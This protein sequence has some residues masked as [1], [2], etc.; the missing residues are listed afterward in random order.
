MNDEEA[1][2]EANRILQ[3]MLPGLAAKSSPCIAVLESTQTAQGFF[4]GVPRMPIGMEWPRNKVGPLGFLCQ[5][6]LGH[7]PNNGSGAGGLT[8]GSLLFFYDFLAQPWGMVVED[9]DSWAVLYSP[10]PMSRLKPFDPPE[11]IEPEI[12]LET[13]G[14]TLQAI[15]PLPSLECEGMDLPDLPLDVNIHWDEAFYVIRAQAWG[16][17]PEHQLF[18]KPD[19][20][21]SDGM[22]EECHTMLLA[23]MK[24]EEEN[25]SLAR[26]LS[27]RT[28]TS[29]AE[30]M[31][32]DDWTLLLQLD[33]DD[34]RG[35]MWG[36]VG[37]LYFFIRKQDLAACRFDRVWLKLQCH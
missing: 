1:K 9:L 7:L 22:E 3:S 31:S 6:D 5:F 17:G 10:D 33:T 11:D 34:D 28:G 15:R 20:I 4:G 26:R 24:A 2:S 27:K 18:G 19:P 25:G 21:Q 14:L 29:L 16:G 13:T 23:R 8:T 35:F 32:Q 36:D 37:R 30:P 12:E